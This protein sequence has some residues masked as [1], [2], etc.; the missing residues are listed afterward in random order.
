ML[1]AARFLSPAEMGVFALASGVAF[2]FSRIAESGW[3]QYAISK[4]ERHV[5][6]T[7]FWSAVVWGSSIATL[8]A[9]CAGYVTWFMGQPTF[10]SIVFVFSVLIPLT[11]VVSVLYGLLTARDQVQTI[12]KISSVADLLALAAAYL[13]FVSGLGIYALVI[14]RV[15][16]VAITFVASIA[17]TKWIPR[18]Q[19]DLSETRTIFSFTRNILGAN[20]VYFAQA[21]GAEFLIGLFLG[22]SQV[23]LYRIGAR[24][25]GAVFELMSEPVRMVSWSQ[26]SLASRTEGSSLA[27]EAEAIV[28]YAGVFALPAFVGL[29]ITAPEIVELVLGPQWAYSAVIIQILAVRGLVQMIAV[30]N[31]PVLSIANGLSTLLRLSMISSASSLVLLCVLAPFGAGFAAFSQV[32][33]ALLI[34]PFSVAAQIRYIGM[35]WTSVLARLWPALL[36]LAAMLIVDTL[37][38]RSFASTSVSPWIVL[39]ARIGLGGAAYLSIT[40][41]LLLLMTRLKQHRV[42]S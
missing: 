14:N 10:G 19:L 12:P 7:L 29:I 18:L 40:F 37:V 11:S 16:A 2:L 6:P 27:R 4:G 24:I 32:L 13:A 28:L 36:G 35:K 21:Y 34:V 31:E 38:T 39:L 17:T 3:M 8:G 23:G 1:V 5:S 15:T 41:P 33:A 20:L 30:I 25:S 22:A 9:L 42:R 26:L